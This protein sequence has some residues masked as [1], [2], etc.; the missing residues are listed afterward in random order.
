MIQ[1]ESMKHKINLFLISTLWLLA[2]ILGASFLI[3]TQFGFNIFSAAHW[4][5]LGGLQ[6][7]GANIDKLF[8][9]FMGG[10]LI[11]AIFGLFL[12]I[13]PMPRKINMNTEPAQKPDAINIIP[14]IP[15]TPD[16]VRPPRLTIEKTN[17]YMSAKSDNLQSS[18]ELNKIDYSSDIQK[19]FT[20][21]KYIIKKPPKILL[22]KPV[23][24]AV[25]ADEV[26]W[27]GCQN[28]KISDF[29]VALNKVES[30]F[31]ETLE[32]IKITIKPFII[33]DQASSD[34]IN[35]YKSVD[36]LRHD[37]PENRQIS[38]SETEDFQAYS[39]YIDTVSDY[40]SKL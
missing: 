35:V 10:S 7:S 14:N 18:S 33:D 2:I 4:Q 3:N 36:E 11:L 39:D 25:G 30:I 17:N 24:F 1:L 19:I 23:L 5:Y 21:A 26:L 22:V 6:A 27:I 13:H 8:Y 20:D 28:T 32:D 37:V 40:L 31:T 29:E 16:M 9:V 38:D 15:N 34:K 12:L